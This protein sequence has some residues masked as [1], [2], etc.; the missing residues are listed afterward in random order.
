MKHTPGKW[1]FGQLGTV[2]CGVRD[3][4]HTMTVPGTS[5]SEIEANGKLIAAAPDLLEAC[6]KIYA[7][8]GDDDCY[9]AGEFMDLAQEL[10]HNAIMK[11]TE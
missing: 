5:S 11:A 1:E 4:D 10:T 7:W 3:F 2:I 6:Q 8:L 9:D